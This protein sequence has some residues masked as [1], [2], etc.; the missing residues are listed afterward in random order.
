AAALLTPV[1]P[2]QAQTKPPAPPPSQYIQCINPGQPLL[3]IPEI[4]SANGKLRGV[5]TLRTEA[6]RMNLGA[7]GNQCVAQPV[8]AFR[9]AHGTLPGYAGSIPVGFKDATVPQPPSQY[10]DPMPGPTLRA[11]VGDLVQ[12]TLLN[13]VDT[14]PFGDSIDRAEHGMG[15]DESSA[16]YPSIDKFPDCFHGSSTGN[17][18]YHGTHTNP[19]TTGDNVF[20][21]IRPSPR[22]NGEPVVTEKSVRKSM[23]QFF[24][25][26][27]KA[28][29]KDPLVQWPFSWADLPKSYVSEQTKLLKAY[30]RDRANMQKLWPVDQAQL[31]IGAWPQYYIGAYPSCFRLPAYQESTWPPTA[32][33]IPAAPGI[34]AMAAAKFGKTIKLPAGHDH[35]MTKGGDMPPVPA[36]RPLVMGQSPGTHWYHAHKHG[37]TTIN[38][39]NGMTGL[40]VIEGKY[41]DDLNAYYGAGWTRKQP[42][43]QINELG[44]SPN[45]FTGK[46][47]PLPFQV[48][49]RPQPTVSMKSGEVQMWRLSNG[50]ARSGA[51]FVGPPTGF[52]WKQIAQDGV[53]LTP[54]NYWNNENQ[55]FL[56]SA[57]NRVDLLVKAPVNTGA[58]TQSF[59][60]QVRQSVNDLE[61]AT[62]PLMTL[63]TVVVEPGPAVTGNAATFVPQDQAPTQPPFLTDVIDSEIAGTQTIVF[64]SVAPNPAPP[65]GVKAPFT[66]QTINGQKF[67]GNIGEVILLN[68]AQEWKIVNRTTNASQPGPINH[69]FHIH[70]NPFQ[71][72]EIFDPQAPYLDP[73]THKPVIIPPP[74]PNPKNVK[75]DY[76]RL[77]VTSAAAKTYDGQCVL[78]PLDEST[79]K[80][81]AGDPQPGKTGRI[82][83][84]VFG[85]PSGLSVTV[86]N[87]PI[88]IPG[89]FKMRS[90]FVDYTGQWVIH[91]HIL[92][93]EDRGMM[94][95][96]EVVPFLTPYSHH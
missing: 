89:Y 79:W 81:C 65:A 53:Q 52:A 29:A 13:Q 36:P 55:P 88:V 54:A 93:H 21:E 45:L 91:C 51:Y 14:G 70:I 60:V 61:N 40:F 34:M 30:D 95:V 43:M 85:M 26:C 64:E 66:Q 6:N 31:D 72:V 16:P 15:C 28:L 83:W 92:A 50:A 76:V 87:K 1:Q 78:D 25:T 63:L 22:K 10:A 74:S 58:T 11:R 3:R 35:Q 42:L 17:I 41:D 8:R 67:D 46:R 75:A 5:I 77:Y 2:V 39:N 7:T 57:G 38:V 19:T 86:D 33:M 48:N 90:R 18:H 59:D 69:P 24:A 62:N 37:S 96:V 23:D 44:V 94:N 84:D 71:V 56:M 68:R 80:P 12:L 20:I 27:E 32:P 82:W 73:T 9:A 49:G 4:V 47:G